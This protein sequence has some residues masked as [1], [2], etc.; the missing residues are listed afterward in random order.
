VPAAK[1]A[2]VGLAPLPPPTATGPQATAYGWLID[3][4][5]TSGGALTTLVHQGKSD[6]ND[7]ATGLG[8]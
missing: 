7:R 1:S 8:S 6:M 3:I 5:P 2:I 4:A